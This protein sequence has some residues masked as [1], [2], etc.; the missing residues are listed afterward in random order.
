MPSFAAPPKPG[1][2]LRVGVTGHRP[3]ER[4]SD[5]AMTR[6]KAEVESILARLAAAAR[7]TLDHN[8][9]VF[10][11][12]PPALRLISALA[13]GADRIAAEA[14]LDA[15]WALEVVL[16]FRRAAYEEDFATEASKR[17]FGALLDRAAAVFCLAMPTEQARRPRAY[18]AAGHLTLDNCDLLLAI[19]DGKRPHG[20]GGTAEIVEEALV[21]GIPVLHINAVVDVPTTL[22]IGEEPPA[23]LKADLTGL[24]TR[25]VAPPADRAALMRY[26]G[27]GA[28][29]AAARDGRILGWWRFGGVFSSF[30]RWFGGG[31]H[32]DFPELAPVGAARNPADPGAAMLIARHDAADAVSTHLGHVYRSAFVLVF[33]ASACA[34]LAGLVG[35]F[36][37]TDSVT[38]AW[39]VGVELLFVAILLL[40]TRRGQGREWHRRWLETR[41]LAEVL[42][43]AAA[44]APAGGGAPIAP[45]TTETDG[46]WTEWY[47]RASLRET[48][49]PN[50]TAD[51]RLLVRMADGFVA[52]LLDPQIDYHRRNTQWLHALHHGLD[53]IGM[54]LFWTTLAIGLCFV[55]FIAVA[56]GL[57][58]IDLDRGPL[59]D[60]F[61]ALIKPAVTL[62]SA[63][64]P[65]LGAALYGIRAQ[66]DY[67]ASASRSEGTARALVALRAR[68]VAARGSPDIVQLRGLFAEAAEIMQSDLS[69]WRQI[70]R[71]R[72]IAIPA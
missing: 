59:H 49:M 50:T 35:I 15:G 26:F 52:D 38:K 19:W 48:H 56:K 46:A 62:C 44:L 60:V 20:Q 27:E 42:R 32:A 1:L 51:A 40:L 17:A 71:H 22:L 70:Y 7:V 39:F 10:A 23:A 5:Q 8:A 25:L 29:D 55:A 14:A 45:T 67:E 28:V 53:R 66:G 65:A 12:S 37:W 43:V 57:H 61:D 21:R 4:L 11:A 64:L 24:V 2:A 41:R 31:H 72:P 69:D 36:W 18:E 68:I 3:G 16:P 9:E 34:V 30:A 47:A 13:E 58:L 63:G 33:L 54:A 6:A